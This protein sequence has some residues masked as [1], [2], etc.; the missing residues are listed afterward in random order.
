[1]MTMVPSVPTFYLCQLVY[2]HN[3]AQ[4]GILL[5]L[6]P[7][8]RRILVLLG[9]QMLPKS[10]LEVLRCVSLPTTILREMFTS[11]HF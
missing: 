5:D 10:C 8:T 2:F 6:L 9:S 3:M 1:M 11:M 7:L 4:V